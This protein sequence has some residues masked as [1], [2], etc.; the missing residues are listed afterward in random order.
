M[1]RLEFFFGQPELEF[2]FFCRAYRNFLPKFNNNI[3]S[4]GYM[5]KTLNQIFFFFHQNQNIFLSNIGN[6]NIFF[7]KNHNPPYK[8]NGPSLIIMLFSPTLMSG[9]STLSATV[10]VWKAVAARVIR[11]LVAGT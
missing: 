2:I 1:F 10:A 8:L 5:A 4:L 9:P 11:S 7:E 6:Q 3:T